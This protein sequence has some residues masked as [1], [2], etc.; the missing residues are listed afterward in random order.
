M[1]NFDCDN[2]LQSMWNKV[3]PIS[4]LKIEPRFKAT[5]YHLVDFTI[6]RIKTCLE[7]YH[8]FFS[9]FWNKKSRLKSAPSQRILS[10]N[11]FLM[12]PKINKLDDALKR[13]QNP[14][15]GTPA[16]SHRIPQLSDVI[17]KNIRY[18]MERAF[19][20]M[21][22]DI[23]RQFW[24]GIEYWN[25]FCFFGIYHEEQ[26]DGVKNA[27]CSRTRAS[28]CNVYFKIGESGILPFCFLALLITA[29]E[30]QRGL[31]PAECDGA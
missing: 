18:G 3:V 22:Y 4:L 13:N 19:G 9:W 28:K 2:E 10:R 16:Q 21:G 11:K 17:Q 6:K 26:I 31:D 29:L 20:T 7:D 30:T 25:P 14:Q 12:T 15:T 8:S 1:Y 24:E 5:L 27:S 23:N